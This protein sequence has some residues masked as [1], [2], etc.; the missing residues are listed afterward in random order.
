[1]ANG[2]FVC[3]TETASINAKHVPIKSTATD[4]VQYIDVSVKWDKQ[5]GGYAYSENGKPI[6][7]YKAD[8]NYFTAIATGSEGAFDHVYG[9]H[10]VGDVPY[11]DCYVDS[12]KG[13][14]RV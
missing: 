13:F 10:G 8:E 1:L 11:W 6:D 14:V 2:D 12:F 3:G 9:A 5:V 7:G 4:A